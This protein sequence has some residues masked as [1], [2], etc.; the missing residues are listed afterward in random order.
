MLS[1][2]VCCVC[3]CVSRGRHSKLGALACEGRIIHSNCTCWKFNTN[4]QIGM[5]FSLLIGFSVNLSCEAYCVF[6]ILVHTAV[7]HCFLYIYIFIWII[8]FNFVLY[9][10]CQIIVELYIHIS[11]MFVSSFPW[12]EIFAS[13]YVL[14]FAEQA[15]K[16]WLSERGLTVKGRTLTEQL[17]SLQIQACQAKIGAL[18]LLMWYVFSFCV[19]ASIHR[20]RIF[21]CMQVS[22][23]FNLDFTRRAG[24]LS[25]V[26]L[27]RRSWMFFALR[28]M[29]AWC[30]RTMKTER[31]LYWPNLKMGR[32]HLL[33][34]AIEL[35]TA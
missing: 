30:I 15:R 2:H 22:S 27:S 35:P 14:S 31:W 32:I 17:S 8:A 7:A 26:K 11:Y 25:K 9:F 24:N 13:R 4:S 34:N 21:R 16:D 5:K 6:I 23:P 18:H 29:Q 28:S 10:V 19:L 33:G 1:F 12:L 20:C 3:D